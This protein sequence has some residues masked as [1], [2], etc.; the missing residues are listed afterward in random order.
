MF[1]ILLPLHSYFNRKKN[2]YNF[3]YNSYLFLIIQF[4]KE[5]AKPK[6][7]DNVT[8]FGLKVHDNDDDV[9]LMS[10]S[11]DDEDQVAKKKR[12]KQIK[13]EKML[14]KVS[15]F[16]IEENFKNKVYFRYYSPVLY[17]FSLIKIKQ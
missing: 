8:S 17:Y 6:K 15:V 5:S 13:K 4:H 14:E 10:S 2:C 1:V 12:E 16:Y 9:G 11:D 3:L 7:S